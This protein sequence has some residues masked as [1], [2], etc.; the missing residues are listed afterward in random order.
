MY[1]VAYALVIGFSLMVKRLFIR[2][3][4]SAD[5]V[6]LSV[7]WFPVSSVTSETAYMFES[8]SLPPTRLEALVSGWT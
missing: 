7:R 8:C 5:L 2:L 1:C 6:Q 4:M 3:Y